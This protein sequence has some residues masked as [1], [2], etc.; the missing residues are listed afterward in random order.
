MD[1]KPQ[2]RRRHWPE[3]T[4]ASPPLPA[5]SFSHEEWVEDSVNL[6]N[7][8]RDTRPEKPV[9]HEGRWRVQRYLASIQQMFGQ[10]PAFKDH[11]VRGDLA[12]LILALDA[13]DNY[14]EHEML[15]KRKGAN[16][17]PETELGRQFRLTVL[18][19][20]DHLISTGMKRNDAYRFV[21]TELTAAGQ[22]ALK[23]GPLGPTPP[24]DWKTIKRWY[25]ATRFRYKKGKQAEKPED[26]DWLFWRA[27]ER[28]CQTLSEAQ[29]SVRRLL[30][31]PVV[32]A[33]FP[34][35]VKT[36]S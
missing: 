23:P 10:H 18:Q 25:E 33:L 3:P 16:K 26:A 32:Q 1:D 4:V 36:P 5:P 34:K 22:G 9:P 7:H 21:A 12:T 14:V 19:M 29:Q 11:A 15:H 27:H 13:L 28:Q 8:M 24:F 2:R 20:V 30:A 31:M 6:L 17:A 35:C